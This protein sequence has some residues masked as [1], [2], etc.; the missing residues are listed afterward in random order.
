[1][2]WPRETPLRYHADLLY[3]ALAIQLNC[4]KFLYDPRT[5]LEN[6]RSLWLTISFGIMAFCER[7]CLLWIRLL[8][9]RVKCQWLVLLWILGRTLIVLCPG[10]PLCPQ[11][12]VEKS[13]WLRKEQIKLG[14]H[15][16]EK[17]D[18]VYETRNHQQ[19]CPKKY[20]YSSLKFV[21]LNQENRSS[22]VGI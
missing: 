6:K 18:G 16:S 5:Q 2:P 15:S 19:L 7:I 12:G 1:M 4:D 21:K 11:D 3:W 17:G 14:N 8:R 9:H 13:F 20:P 10:E 22:Y